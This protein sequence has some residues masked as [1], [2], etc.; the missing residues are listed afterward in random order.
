MSSGSEITQNHNIQQA[1][2]RKSQPIVDVVTLSKAYKP[3]F[4]AVD[5][6]SLQ[7]YEGEIFGF[8]G[9]NGA[10][11]TT[12]ISIL[13]TLLSPTSGSAKVAGYDIRKNS[14]EVRRMIGVVQQ[15]NTTDKHLTAYENLILTARL[16]G[17]P[18]DLA[19]KRARE[20][21]ELVELS[22]VTERKVETYSGGMRRRLEIACGLV[23]RPRVLF[24]DEPTLGLDVQT[25]SAIWKYVKKLKEENLMTLFLTTHYM[26]EADSLCDRIAIIDHGRIITVGSPAEL[27]SK[28][29]G[30]I[31]ELG[32]KGENEDLSEIITKIPM[33]KSVTKEAS[34]YRIKAE[35]G[36][37]AALSIIDA[38]RSKGYSVTKILV[39]KPSLSEVYLELTGEAFREEGSGKGAEF[40]GKT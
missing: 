26:E 3:D 9:P 23:N 39:N 25:R 36:D 6:I 31:I 12:T 20:L 7:V 17:V 40:L 24:L 15:D 29:G 34:L 37:E 8:L 33:V 10:G 4:K 19:Q 16:Q 32:V 14:S 11:K 21:L 5:N 30:D 22:D 27:K 2:V 13:T 38:V 18:R 28:L 35:N 1:P